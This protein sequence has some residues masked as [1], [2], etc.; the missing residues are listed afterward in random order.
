MTALVQTIIQAMKRMLLLLAAL[1]MLAG[2]SSVRVNTDHAEDADFS[3]FRTF[4]YQEGS[5][6][7]AVT[8]PLAHQRIVAALRR[9]MTAAGLTEVE[10][11]PDVRVTYHGSTERQIEFRTTYTGGSNWGRGSWGSRNV[12]VGMSTSTTRPTTV[13]QGTLVI[14][15]WEV[16]GN[17]L[18]WRGVV[19]RSVS[20]NPSRNTAEINRGIDAAFRRFPP[21]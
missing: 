8:D 4:Q 18:V 20:S 7:V 6:T 11:D 17:R 9:N 21:S 2:C 19:S 3:Q 15:I 13:T 12:G 14:D 5:N 10:S 16:A 1:G